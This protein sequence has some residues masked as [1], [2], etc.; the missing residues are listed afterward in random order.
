MTYRLK[1]CL[2]APLL[3]MALL[4]PSFHLVAAESSAAPTTTSTATKRPD[5]VYVPTPQYV[6]DRML[7]VA[8]VRPDDI[9]GKAGRMGGGRTWIISREVVYW[10][11]HEEVVGTEVGRATAAERG[12]SG[13]FC[14]YRD[15]DRPCLLIDRQDSVVHDIDSHIRAT[16]GTEVLNFR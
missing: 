15:L 8:E 11:Q 12:A 5:V 14:K 7:E 13:A 16:W 6:V 9:V 10:N 1:G 2:G 3:A 4:A